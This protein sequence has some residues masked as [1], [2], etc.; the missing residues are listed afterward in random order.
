MRPFLVWQLSS[1]DSSLTVGLWR[2]CDCFRSSLL[3]LAL[4]FFCWT[5]KFHVLH[6]SW[7][8]NLMDLQLLVKGAHPWQAKL[9]GI[10]MILAWGTVR[11]QKHWWSALPAPASCQCKADS[12]DMLHV[13][14]QHESRPHMEP[15]RALLPCLE[16]F[17]MLLCVPASSWNIA[18][19][20]LSKLQSISCGL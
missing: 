8:S 10:Y 17:Y 9:R 5:L 18:V 13:G 12:A 1:E 20:V 14:P 19:W 15:H 3:N 11:L 7:W 4:W 6:P 16:P 2:F